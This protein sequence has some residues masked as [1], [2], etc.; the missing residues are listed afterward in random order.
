[1]LEL[2]VANKSKA[3]IEQNSQLKKLLRLLNVMQMR[4]SC[5]HYQ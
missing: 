5:C 1:M 4:N 2:R 3:Y